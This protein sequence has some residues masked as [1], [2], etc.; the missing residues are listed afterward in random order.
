MVVGVLGTLLFPLLLLPA[1]LH[2]WSHLDTPCC[3]PSVPGSGT[4]LLLEGFLSQKF[5][6]L[7]L[8]VLFGKDALHVPEKQRV[9]QS[10]PLE[11]ITSHMANNLGFLWPMLFL[12]FMFLWP[13]A[14]KVS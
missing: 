11:T 5:I 4:P 8:F 6:K 1:P 10:M 3:S 13:T 2:S 14:F 12:S 9:S 7:K